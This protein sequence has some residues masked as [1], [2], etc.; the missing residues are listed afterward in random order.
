MATSSDSVSPIKLVASEPAPGDAL[1]VDSPL[2]TTDDEAASNAESDEGEDEP[3]LEGPS[4]LVA[5][6]PR[7]PRVGC[8]SAMMASPAMQIKFMFAETLRSLKVAAAEDR[9]AEALGTVR[10]R[11]VAGLTAIQPEHS[12]SRSAALARARQALSSPC[13]ASA[14]RDPEPREASATSTL[15]EMMQKERELLSAKFR[16]VRHEVKSFRYEISEDVRLAHKSRTAPFVG[17]AQSERR[18]LPPALQAA[19]QKRNE[20]RQQQKR[21]QD[22]PAVDTALQ[23]KRACADV[24]GRLREAAS[25]GSLLRDVSAIRDLLLSQLSSINPDRYKRELCLDRG[26]DG[27]RSQTAAD[28]K[29]NSVSIQ[30]A[31]TTLD[32]KSCLESVLTD[33]GT[34]RSVSTESLELHSLQATVSPPLAQSES[35]APDAGMVTEEMPP[36]VL[37]GKPGSALRPY[38]IRS[39]SSSALRTSGGKKDFSNAHS[40]LYSASFLKG[41]WQPRALDQAALKRQPPADTPA[42]LLDLGAGAASSEAPRSLT[43]GARVSKSFTTL[44]PLVQ[45]PGR[46]G[47]MALAQ[48]AAEDFLGRSSFAV[49]GIPSAL[50]F[51]LVLR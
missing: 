47:S 44:P 42:M 4:V 43:S 2:V 16:A 38:L 9:L 40:G 32:S 24:V 45:A 37:A 35:C 21:M 26:A 46:L 3:E 8:Q 1:V 10:N 27:Q 30:S 19:M 18:G 5:L 34:P 39:G 29:L 36:V 6:P 13:P 51:G 49:S 11:F 50:R 22:P 20:R 14:A 48:G 25:N 12:D 41:A 33:A 28:E 15:S 31:D 23:T 7:P 17:Q